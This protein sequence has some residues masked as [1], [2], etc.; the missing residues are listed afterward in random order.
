M[1]WA[2]ER[3]SGKKWHNVVW[4]TNERLSGKRWHNAMWWTTERLSGKTWY[5]VIWWTNERLSGKRWHNAMWWT[6]ERL[7][8]KRWH[9]VIWWTTERL[10]G[11]RWDLELIVKPSIP[12]V[13][14]APH[15]HQMEKRLRRE[16]G[17]RPHQGTLYSISHS[18]QSVKTLL[19]SDQRALSLSWNPLFHQ[20]TQC[21]TA[22]RRKP[23]E[24]RGGD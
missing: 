6:T 3:P 2:T 20:S 15:G 4:W 12:P 5:N 10:S 23:W 1:W 18:V 16:A 8:G 14:S 22:V 17:L 7:S 24:E 11:K 21:L 13:N 9:N 19:Q